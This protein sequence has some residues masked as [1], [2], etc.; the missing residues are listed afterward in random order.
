MFADALPF[1]AP[2]GRKGRKARKHAVGIY[3]LKAC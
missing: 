1:I 2:V 3:I